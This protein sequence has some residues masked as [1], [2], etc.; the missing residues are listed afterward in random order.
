MK[1]ASTFRNHVLALEREN[2]RKPFGP[3]FED[4]CS[5]GS[6]CIGSAAAS[7][8]ALANELFMDPR[9]R[10]RPLLTSKGIFGPRKLVSIGSHLFRNIKLRSTNLDC[11]G[12]MRT[13]A[14]L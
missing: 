12:W 2:D 8:E 5:Y 9:G 1:A 11:S 13:A 4:I 3:F 6:A 10:L 14:F 7:I